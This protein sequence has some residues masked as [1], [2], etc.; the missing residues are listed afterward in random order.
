MAIERVKSRVASGGHD[1][2]IDVIKRRYIA[3]MDN[4][5]RLYLPI[6]DYWM[7]IDNSKAPFQIVSEG[8][9]KTNIE[10]Y[11]QDIYNKIVKA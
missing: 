2:P 9:K 8:F 7:I 6:S 5:A 11:N 3:G 10:I 4:L 1:I